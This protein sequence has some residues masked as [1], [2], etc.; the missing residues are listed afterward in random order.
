MQEHT[1]ESAK[2][3][4]DMTPLEKFQKEMEERRRQRENQSK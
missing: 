1:Q 4:E 2:R 3:P